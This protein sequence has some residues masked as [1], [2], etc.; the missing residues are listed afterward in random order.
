M[1]QYKIDINIYIVLLDNKHGYYKHNKRKRKRN[2]Q[3]RL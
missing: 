1:I 3:C 2:N